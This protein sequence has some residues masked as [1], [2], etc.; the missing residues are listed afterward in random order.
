MDEVHGSLEDI[1]LLTARARARSSVEAVRTVPQY[2]M[3]VGSVRHLGVA[4]PAPVPPSFFFSFCA[5]FMHATE[6]V[7]CVLQPFHFFISTLY[8]TL[9]ALHMLCHASPMHLVAVCRSGPR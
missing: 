5:P 3:P 6:A 8:S 9:L 7:F 4:V 2:C 1:L